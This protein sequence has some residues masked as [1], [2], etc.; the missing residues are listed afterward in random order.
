MWMAHLQHQVQHTLSCRMSEAEF[1][2]HFDSI[3]YPPPLLKIGSVTTV[4][5]IS[6]SKWPFSSISSS[7][8][9]M[10]YLIVLSVEIR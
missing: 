10:S 6:P 9:G 2:R 5:V 8:K 3:R 4:T 7:G 1:A